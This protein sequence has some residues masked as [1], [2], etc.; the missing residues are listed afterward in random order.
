MDFGAGVG[1]SSHDPILSLPA[2]HTLHSLAV[3]IGTHPTV[4]PKNGVCD[5]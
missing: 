3:P 1:L 4:L 5:P 2:A